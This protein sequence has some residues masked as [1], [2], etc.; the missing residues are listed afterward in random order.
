M[1][2]LVCLDEEE[3]EEMMRP[4]LQ[5][6]QKTRSVDM[7]RWTMA[8]HDPGLEVVFLEYM[9]WAFVVRLRVI[10][11]VLLVINLAY[12]LQEYFVAEPDHGPVLAIRFGGVVMAIAMFIGSTF[13]TSYLRYMQA[14]LVC[15]LV[16][17]GVL[18]LI[19]LLT[20][21]DN[22]AP[23]DRF[24][25]ISATN[26][27]GALMHANSSFK[28]RFTYSLGVSIVL[29]TVYVVIISVTMLEPGFLE[30]SD[31]ATYLLSFVA[32]AIVGTALTRFNERDLRRLFILTA[33]L[34]QA[35]QIVLAERKV[36]ELSP[37]ARMSLFGGSA[38]GD[39][40]WLPPAHGGS[41]VRR[42]ADEVIV[43]EENR[44]D[45]NGEA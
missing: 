21:P 12:G 40:P 33:L 38:G 28:L 43:L 19:S 11:G 25:L 7:Y 23:Q 16:A 2:E 32:I 18:P 17:E 24:L 31:F 29:I 42:N 1:E 44:D 3:V 27:A 9:A 45:V 26:L 22:S 30:A 13:F 14:F 37:T 41:L 6:V 20:L 10:C 15:L 36:E 35:Q 4:R 5:S 34:D 8:F 39:G